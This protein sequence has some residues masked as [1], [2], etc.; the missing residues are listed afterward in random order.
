MVW[1]AACRPVAIGGDD[2]WSVPVITNGPCLWGRLGP[3]MWL[4]LWLRLLQHYIHI[5]ILYNCSITMNRIMSRITFNPKYC[6]D[7]PLL[8]G[9]EFKMSR[10][11]FRNRF[12]FLSSAN[13]QYRFKEKVTKYFWV[14]QI[15]IS[16]SMIPSVLRLCLC[17]N[18]LTALLLS[19]LSTFFV[20]THFLI[21]ENIARQ[22]FVLWADRAGWGKCK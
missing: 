5:I 7:K 16:R 3:D 22:Q 18:L 17:T 19:H 10:S 2:A 13:L 6:F 9:F 21:F 11:I 1:H 14:K 12:F 4:G 15:D 8:R 20:Y